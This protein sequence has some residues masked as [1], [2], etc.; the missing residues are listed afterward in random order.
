MV[1]A[2]WPLLEADNLCVTFPV[3]GG[4]AEAGRARGKPGH[5]A[6]LSRRDARSGRRIRQ[7]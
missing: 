4:G 6:D 5:D 3:S 2:R 1:N 7:R